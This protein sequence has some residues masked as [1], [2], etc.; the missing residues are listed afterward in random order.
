MR[1]AYPAVGK[2]QRVRRAAPRP[3]AAWPPL[4][5]VRQA[6]RIQAAFRGWR[7][8]CLGL[9]RRMAAQR[10]QGWLRSLRVAVWSGSTAGVTREWRQRDLVRLVE[11]CGAAYAFRAHELAAL[12][13]SSADFRHPVTRRTLLY[14][15]FERVCRAVPPGARLCLAATWRNAAEARRALYERDSLLNFYHSEAGRHLDALLE[16]AEEPA[17]SAEYRC[18]LDSYEDAV[19]EIQAWMPLSASEALAQ[20]GRLIAKRLRLCSDEAAEEIVETHRSLVVQ[21]SGACAPTPQAALAVWMLSG[22][23]TKV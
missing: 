9:R 2:R 15:E 3:P 23:G 17:P 10:I 6:I 1:E 14:P 18:A 19:L 5:H 21:C 20:H 22:I 4:E 8:R 12:F 11:P 13:V 7:A 16:H